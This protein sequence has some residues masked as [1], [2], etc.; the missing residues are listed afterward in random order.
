VAIWETDFYMGEGL[1]NLFIS[2]LWANMIQKSLNW[3]QKRE[4]TSQ[5]L[6]EKEP[7]T[8]PTFLLFHYCQPCFEPN[9]QRTS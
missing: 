8:S 7:T 2:F 9:P 1:Q 3:D 4:D 5:N 6:K